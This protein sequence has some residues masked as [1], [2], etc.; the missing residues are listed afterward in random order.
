VHEARAATAAAMAARRPSG[1]HM[2]E[3][4]VIP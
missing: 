1:R 4:R 3:V 2:R